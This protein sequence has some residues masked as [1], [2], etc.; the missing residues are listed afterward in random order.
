MHDSQMSKTDGPEEPPAPVALSLSVVMITMN[1][2]QAV[3]RV[4][5]EIRAVAA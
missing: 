3:A 2:E 4:I 1:E 5:G